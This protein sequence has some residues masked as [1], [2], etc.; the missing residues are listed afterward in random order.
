LVFTN[1]SLTSDKLFAGG[2]EV[3]LA[4]VVGDVITY[5]KR[6]ENMFS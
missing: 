3:V 5:K 1:L 6:A 2:F 4:D